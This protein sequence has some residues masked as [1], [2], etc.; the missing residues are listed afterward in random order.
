MLAG[1]DFTDSDCCVFVDADSQT[2]LHKVREMLQEY[3]RGYD[4]VKA[5]KLGE[6]T[7]GIQGA[8]RLAFYKLFQIM[9]SVSL[10]DRSSDFRHFGKSAYRSLRQCRERT[11]FSKAYYEDIGFRVGTVEFSLPKRVAGET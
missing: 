4:I 8:S 3:A 10:D 6:V 2:P 5:V 1:L 7:Q 9:S 11:R